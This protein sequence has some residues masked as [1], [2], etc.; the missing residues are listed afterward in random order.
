M[1]NTQ[2]ITNVFDGI[3]RNL[4]S[5]CKRSTSAQRDTFETRLSLSRASYNRTSNLVCALGSLI[6]TQH[7]VIENN[8]KRIK[9][10]TPLLTTASYVT[11]QSLKLCAATDVFIQS[12]KGLAHVGMLYKYFNPILPD[13][14][15]KQI[16][17]LDCLCYET[18][19]DIWVLRQDY[20]GTPY[21]HLEPL[22]CNEKFF[23]IKEDLAENLKHE[24]FE[25]INLI[26]KFM[27]GHIDAIKKSCEGHDQNLYNQLSK[28]AHEMHEQSV[29]IQN[30]AAKFIKDTEEVISKRGMSFVL[31][32]K[33]KEARLRKV[34]AYKESSYY[35]A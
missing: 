35:D 6:D 31:T 33:M 3:F 34:E 26:D 12:L 4:L 13:Q 15:S 16:D 10:Y 30:D 25:L 8:T 24:I 27:S 32:K 22:K 14:K 20:D 2:T 1:T 11:D 21:K 23:R 28:L 17:A 7:K 9:L 5:M 19:M 18:S 29:R